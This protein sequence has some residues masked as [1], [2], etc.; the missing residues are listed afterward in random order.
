[1]L[2]QKIAK[3]EVINADYIP[4]MQRKERAQLYTN[5]KP[6]EKKYDQKHKLDRGNFKKLDPNVKRLQE[7]AL[8]AQE[9]LKKA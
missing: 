3:F 5:N 4:I 7:E 2:D 9:M 6:L 8:K 1:M